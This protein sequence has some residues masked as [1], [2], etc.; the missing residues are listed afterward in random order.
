MFLDFREEQKHF[1]VEDLSIY[2]G[3]YEEFRGLGYKTL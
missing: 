2:S 1:L 3:S